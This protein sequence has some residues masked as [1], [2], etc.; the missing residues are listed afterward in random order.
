MNGITLRHELRPGDVAEVLRLHE[1][2]YAQEYGFDATF[3][4]HVAG[5]LN[6][7][8]R[9]PGERER[10]WLAE[11]DGRTVGCIAVVQAS[12]REAQLRWFLVDPSARGHGLGRRLMTEAVAFSRAQGYDATFLWTVDLL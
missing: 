10:L 9:Q 1:T 3:A 6:A 2:L 12:P 4:D 8:A 7:F 5:P 11:R